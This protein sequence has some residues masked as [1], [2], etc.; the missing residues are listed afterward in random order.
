MKDNEILNLKLKI[1]QSVNIKRKTPRVTF[2]EQGLD[3]VEN[4]KNE[5]ARLESEL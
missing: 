5:I 3:E 4:Y 1:E 2:E